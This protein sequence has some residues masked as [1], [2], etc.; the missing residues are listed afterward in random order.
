MLEEEGKEVRGEMEEAVSWRVA[1]TAVA[2][3]WRE[4]QAREEMA[5]LAWDKAVA[6]EEGLGEVRAQQE[7]CEDAAA[8]ARERV[9]RVSG[10]SDAAIDAAR[11]RGRVE[12]KRAMKA[13]A[14]RLIS[15]TGTRSG[16]QTARQTLTRPATSAPWT[17]CTPW[18]PT[19]MAVCSAWPRA[20]ATW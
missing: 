4:L 19:A 2:E 10:E 11:G 9:A 13:A 3:A 15:V 8:R 18:H 7:A 14:A 5:S 1:M 12:A 17:K 20:F 6:A 16:R